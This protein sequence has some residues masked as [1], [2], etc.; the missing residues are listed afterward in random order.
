MWDKLNISTSDQAA[1]GGQGSPYY[2]P[3]KWKQVTQGEFE[4]RARLL[5]RPV[6]E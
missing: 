4:L 6:G 1:G 2:Q 3:G 5:V